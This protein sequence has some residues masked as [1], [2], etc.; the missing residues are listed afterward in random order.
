MYLCI[1][2]RRVY[3]WQTDETRAIQQPGLL[4]QNAVATLSH[5]SDA[6]NVTTQY[7]QNETATAAYTVI[8]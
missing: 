1:V 6:V 4:R 2:G 8:I 7:N 5:Q 3:S